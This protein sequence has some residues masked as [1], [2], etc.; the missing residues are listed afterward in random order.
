M[1]TLPKLKDPNS[2]EMLS[3]YYDCWQRRK[4]GEPLAK[5]EQ[6]LALRYVQMRDTADLKQ[7]TY[8]PKKLRKAWKPGRP[9]IFADVALD[10]LRQDDGIQSL[11]LLKQK[12]A[13]RLGRNFNERTW[14]DFVRKNHLSDFQ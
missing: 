10:L 5:Y 4:R 3:I 1:R 12:L 14:N 8:F 9:K 6:E 2:V 7:S 13:E 11:A